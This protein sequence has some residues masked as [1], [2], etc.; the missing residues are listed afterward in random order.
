MVELQP[1][2]LTIRVRFPLPAQK[3]HLNNMKKVRD[4]F[5]VESNVQLL[6]VNLVF[7][8]TGTIAVY[9]AGYIVDGFGMDTKRL[10]STVYW[11]LRTVMLIP[12]YQVLLIIVGTIFGEF[13]YF[14][15]ME[16]KMLKKLGIRI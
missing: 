11:T 16:K 7:A 14:W 4:F 10:G 6:V 1:S 9:L 13:S 3:N 8:V 12:I 5:K 15:A 2:K